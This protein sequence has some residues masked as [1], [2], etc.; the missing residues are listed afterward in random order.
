VEGRS[1]CQGC[2][3]LL[4]RP[5]FTDF[6]AVVPVGAV[7]LGA[8]LVILR[9]NNAAPVLWRA[10][11]RLAAPVIVLFARQRVSLY[12]CHCLSPLLVWWWLL[13]EPLVIQSVAAARVPVVSADE[14]LAA[15]RGHA[16]SVWR[17]V[18]VAVEVIVTRA[19]LPNAAKAIR[20]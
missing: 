16:V 2:C 12:L 11:V 14:H 15:M 10:G 17:V 3:W 19:M 4:S 9:A 18:A 20:E 7:A 6:R 13:L 1:G 5:A 8:F